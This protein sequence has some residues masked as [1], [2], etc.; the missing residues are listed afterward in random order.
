[1]IVSL[2][3]RWRSSRGRN[4]FAEL[5]RRNCRR[6]RKY[7]RFWGAVMRRI[8]TGSAG[9]VGSAALALGIWLSLVAQA[10]SAVATA[11]ASGDS[12]AEIIVTAEKRSEDAQKT[13]IA[14]TTISG[15]DIVKRAENQLDTTLRNVPSV[16]VQ[17]TPQG[18][19]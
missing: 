14:I 17:S 1:M 6:L 13:P 10:Q 11:D 8:Y 18:G 19:E 4:S 9:L 16:Q 2:K 7:R 12:L 15:E 3:T 5:H